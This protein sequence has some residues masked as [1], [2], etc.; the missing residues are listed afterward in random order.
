M[1]ALRPLRAVTGAT[2]ADDVWELTLGCGHS[3]HYR[4]SEGG[5][6]PIAFPCRVCPPRLFRGGDTV[7]WMGLGGLRVT[8]AQ[9][10]SF[11][12]CSG[13]PG[14]ML[15]LNAAEL[16]LLV[17]GRADDLPAETQAWAGQVNRMARDDARLFGSEGA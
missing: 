12:S 5:H 7:E 17:E 14:E 9:S 1:T 15:H 10:G 6:A 2:L 4:L 3:A 16:T 8:E 13:G 11:V